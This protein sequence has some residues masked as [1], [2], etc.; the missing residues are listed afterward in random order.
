MWT[1]DVYRGLCCE[2]VLV[3]TAP[4]RARCNPRVRRFGGG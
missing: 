2:K 4:P 3:L 1:C